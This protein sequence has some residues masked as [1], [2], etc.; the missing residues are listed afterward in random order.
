MSAVQTNV[1][2][3]PMPS[4]APPRAL[5]IG[6]LRVLLLIEAALGVAIAIA[7]SM[8]A[9]GASDGSAAGITAEENLRFAAGFAFVSAILAAAAAR[10]V[11]RR[12]AWSWTLAAVLQLLTALGTGAALT[13]A[14]W[15]PAYLLGFA[16]AT[17]V[18]L[19]LSTRSVR[20]ALGQE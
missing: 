2:V 16:A 19:V 15:H 14:T 5:G 9:G 17:I 1:V 11:R 13:I 6:F 18:M 12:R 7:L 20:R 8:V 10:G 3:S 4:A